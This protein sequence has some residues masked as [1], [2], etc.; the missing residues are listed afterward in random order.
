M[1]VSRRRTES[2]SQTPSPREEKPAG[3]EPDT[4]LLQYVAAHLMGPPD[5]CGQPGESY[6]TCPRCASPKWHTLP[7][8]EGY[9]DRFLCWACNYRGDEDDLLAWFYPRETYGQRVD[10]LGRLQAEYGGLATPHP[11]EQN[12]RPVPQSQPPRAGAFPSRGSGFEGD[13][14]TAGLGGSADPYDV[15]EAYRNAPRGR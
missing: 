14:L 11:G 2:D 8:R 13:P 9:K 3:A 15:E 6:W 12:N 1:P 7:R 5:S 10:R 4:T